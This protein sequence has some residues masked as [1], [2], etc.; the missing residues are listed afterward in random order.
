[1]D[2][3]PGPAP[4]CRALKKKNRA[5]HRN[6]ELPKPQAH[7]NALSGPSAPVAA[8]RQAREPNLS[9]SCNCGSSTV[10]CTTQKNQ[11]VA[12]QPA[13]QL[14]C[15]GTGQPTSTNCTIGTSTTKPIPATAGSPQFSALSRHAQHGHVKTFAKNCTVESLVLQSLHPVKQLK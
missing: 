6:N 2:T 8:K 5:H 3:T 1:M 12:Y 7:P 4:V 10:C 11:K 14:P 13:C 15:P 9:M